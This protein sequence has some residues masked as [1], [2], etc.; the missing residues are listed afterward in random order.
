MI[1]IE[2]LTIGKIM[3]LTIR[4]KPDEIQAL[5][6]IKKL[7]NV[8]TSSGAVKTL[9]KK[10]ERIIADYQRIK[11]EN[12]ELQERLKT[13]E[14]ATKN[15]ISAKHK[16]TDMLYGDEWNEE[17]RKRAKRIDNGESKSYT[18]EEIQNKADS[19]LDEI[20]NR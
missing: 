2:I 1:A 13:I 19:Y 8:R 18:L 10:Y 5:D 12:S 3:A 17:L 11:A 9:I 16:L 15:Y 20:T 4:L 7:E 14:H 6:R